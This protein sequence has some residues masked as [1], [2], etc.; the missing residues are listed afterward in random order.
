MSPQQPPQPWP[1]P[2]EDIRLDIALPDGH[3]SSQRLQPGRMV[4]GRSA[5]CDLVLN[6]QKVSR[7][8][9]LLELAGQDLTITDQDSRN[10]VRVAGQRVHSTRLRHGDVVTLGAT[11]IQ[12]HIQVPQ[13]S[14]PAPPAG[15][16]APRTPTRAEKAPRQAGKARA[17][18]RQAGPVSTGRRV[19][20]VVLIVLVPLLVLFFGLAEWD[21][22]RGG[23]LLF[24]P[25]RPLP[26]PQAALPAPAPEPAAPQAAPPT[27][28]PEPA[29]PPR[30]QGAN[31]AVEELFAKGE[32]H[33]ESGRMAEAVKVWRQ[34]LAVDPQHKLVQAKL[35]M[36]EKRLQDSADRAFQQGL[37]NFQ[38][39]NYR[40]AIQNWT[41]VINLIQDPSH[42]LHRKA[43]ENMRIAEQ[44]LSAV[45]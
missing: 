1:A 10:G 6:D 11:R 15:Q 42:E 13:T 9:A 32:T 43:M 29:A 16:P 3:R 20:R 21:R 25:K 38:N 28:G 14:P 35:A 27:P 30:T 36:A 40:E 26:A 23:G 4:I 39:L 8:H 41:H 44:K 34:V 17:G 31:R 7:R 45:R 2:G 18:T 19:A 5:S 12:V 33:Y 24:P 22:Q 37:R